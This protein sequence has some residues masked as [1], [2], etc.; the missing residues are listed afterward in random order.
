MKSPSGWATRTPLYMG[1]HG[2]EGRKARV[3]QDAAGWPVRRIAGDKTRRTPR[4]HHIS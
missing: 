3:P 2:R 4:T 1:M